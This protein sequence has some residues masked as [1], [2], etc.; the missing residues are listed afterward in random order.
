[1]PIPAAPVP[2]SEKNVAPV[3]PPVLAATAPARP[4]GP[5]PDTATS[6]SG[7]DA[8]DRPKDAS[9]WAITFAV[10]SLALLL[11]LG[12]F[13]SKILDRDRSIQAT[14]N[15]SEQ[16]EAGVVAREGLLDEA[17]AISG[18]LQKQLDETKEEIFQLKAAQDKAKLGAD[19]L[20]AQLDKA[21]AGST[22]F[23]TQMEEAKVAS[24]R[25]QGEVEIAQAQT[26]VAQTQADKARSDL[27]GTQ[28][29]LAEARTRADDLQARLDKADKEITQLKK[30]PVKR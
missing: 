29:E 20:Q 6:N 11:L 28:A 22:A 14:K 18:R 27:V 26:A 17:R 13:W 15:R 10:T 4:K 2:G 21:R 19:L 30:L 12:F 7:E 5:A 25:R 3:V 8:D 23:Q 1:M 9:P 24:L 16:I